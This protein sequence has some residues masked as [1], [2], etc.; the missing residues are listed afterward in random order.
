MENKGKKK[1][2]RRKKKCG[3]GIIRKKQEKKCKN[4]SEIKLAAENQK[5]QKTIRTKPSLTIEK[6]KAVMML[7]LLRKL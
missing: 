3:N 4:G 7:L 1:C 6:E 2:D 5:T